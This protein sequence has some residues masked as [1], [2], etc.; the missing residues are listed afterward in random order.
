MQL[1]EPLLPIVLIEKSLLI[2]LEELLSE[3]FGGDTLLTFRSDDKHLL[4]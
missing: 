1:L 2:L 3:L 4:P